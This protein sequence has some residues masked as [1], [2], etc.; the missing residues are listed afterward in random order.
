M[1]FITLNNGISN[2]DAPRYQKFLRNCGM[3]PAVNQ[4]ESHVY[5]PQRSL[6]GWY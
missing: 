6:F 4:V 1:E 3:V 5:F 2:F